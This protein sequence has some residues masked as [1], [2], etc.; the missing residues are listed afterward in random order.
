MLPFQ[1][2]GAEV[3]K[4]ELLGKNCIGGAKESPRVSCWE[5]KGKQY[6]ISGSSL[7]KNTKRLEEFFKGWSAWAKRVFL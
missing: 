1:N 5:G 2:E 3:G 6:F 4:K 7:R